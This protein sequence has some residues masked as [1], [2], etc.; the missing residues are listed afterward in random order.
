MEFQEALIKQT[1]DMANEL[2]N[3]S[4]IC[5]KNQEKI[6]KLEELIE[7]QNAAIEVLKK[8][9]RDGRINSWQGQAFAREILWGEVFNN[10]IRESSWLHN[11]SFSPGRWAVGYEYLYAVYRI[12]DIIKPQNILELGLGQSTRL[13]GQY[14]AANKDV[15]HQIVEHDETWI[16]FFKQDF[17]LADNSTIVQLKRGYRTFREDDQV[18]NFID[19]KKTF[20]K[21]KFDFI[22]IDAPLGADAIIYARIDIL[23]LL[24]DCL[25]KS[26]VIVVDDYNRLGE[27]NMV[28]IL[29]KILTENQIA[30]AKG[31]YVGH[32]DCLV[33]ASENQKFVCT[34]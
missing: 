2:K 20:D 19:F 29:E 22:S 23:E 26:F 24:P 32:K 17:S 8:D 18:R 14:A 13:L 28:K 11:K 4:N 30:Y 7:N 10:M 25:A 27:Q 6:L 21:Q 5:K 12:L 31:T 3:L 34:M 1:Q 33:I 16:K 15:A 9:A